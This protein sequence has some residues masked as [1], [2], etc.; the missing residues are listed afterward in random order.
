MHIRT[1][2]NLIKIHFKVL[3][4]LPNEGSSLSEV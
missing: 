1:Y 2:K 4:P 3:N